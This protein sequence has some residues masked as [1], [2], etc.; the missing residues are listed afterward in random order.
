MDRATRPWRRWRAN[1]LL[2]RERQVADRL[3]L[4]QGPVGH[5][6]GPSKKMRGGSGMPEDRLI[7][8]H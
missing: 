1:G 8:W 3:A 2:D 4:R 7:G 6:R 5:S